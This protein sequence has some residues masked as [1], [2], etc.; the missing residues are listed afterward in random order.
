MYGIRSRPYRC[1]PIRTH[2]QIRK[3]RVVTAA[4]QITIAAVKQC[5]RLFLPKL[6]GPEKL[7]ETVAYL[8][9]DYPN[10]TFIYGSPDAQP[11]AKVKVISPESNTVVFIGPEGGFSNFEIDYFKSLKASAVSI[12]KNI[13]RVETAAVAFCSLLSEKQI[14]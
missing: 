14:P 8:Q 7:K 9:S 2:G 6:T 12:N 10:C 13:L 1:R 3:R 4:F 5:G 11:I